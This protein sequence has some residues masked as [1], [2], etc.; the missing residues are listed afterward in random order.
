MLEHSSS[1]H[2]KQAPSLLILGACFIYETLVV[3]A[4]LF[5]SAFVYLWLFGE[6]THGLKRYVFQFYLWSTV[7]VYFIWCWH[8]NG[9]TLAMKT[10]RL[11]L[12]NQHA[13]LL[14]FQLA[15]LRYVLATV[16]LLFLGLGFIWAVLDK[17]HL[18][19]HDRYLKNKLV[20]IKQS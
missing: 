5:A 20:S 1:P 9:Q 18:Y 3:A 6:A 19:W 15:T 17:E 8:K 2:L 13:Q 4:I 12:F 10:W 7:G 11:K 16:S 14:S